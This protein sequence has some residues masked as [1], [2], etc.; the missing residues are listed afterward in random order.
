MQ[1]L[2]LSSCCKRQV[3]QEIVWKKEEDLYGKRGKNVA[4]SSANW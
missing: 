2:Q 3:H 1:W 4:V